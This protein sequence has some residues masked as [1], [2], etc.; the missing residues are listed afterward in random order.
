M[1]LEHRPADQVRPSPTRE[2]VSVRAAAT[3]GQAEGSAVSGF[4]YNT[5]QLQD[6]LIERQLADCGAKD[7]LEALK[8]AA[9]LLQV[10]KKTEA[11]AASIG[12]LCTAISPTQVRARLASSAQTYQMLVPMLLILSTDRENT[13]PVHAGD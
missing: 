11:D 6:W 10:N 2:R 13:E 3:V 9:L 4:R 1:L 8:Q 7:A 12:G 5:W